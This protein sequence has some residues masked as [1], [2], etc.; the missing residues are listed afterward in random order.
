MESQRLSPVYPETDVRGLYIVWAGD[1]DGVGM[2]DAI[3]TDRAHHN[4]HMSYRVFLSSPAKTRSPG[5]G[6]WPLSLPQGVEPGLK[7][8][9]QDANQ[10]PFENLGSLLC[11]GENDVAPHRH[12]GPVPEK[13][14][15]FTGY[16][17]VP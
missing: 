15:C 11:P 10:N 3:L 17:A 7:G 6:K 13:L 1:P 14:Q 8:P 9:C 12:T 5:E 4:I 16:G 2:I